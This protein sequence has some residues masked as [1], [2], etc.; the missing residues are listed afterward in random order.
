MISAT[1]G[2][3]QSTPEPV[4]PRTKERWAIRKT[5][6]MGRVVMTVAAKAT[7]SGICEP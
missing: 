6:T 4:R 5:T 3:A 7:F 2:A 1:G